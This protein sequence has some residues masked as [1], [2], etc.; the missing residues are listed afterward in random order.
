MGFIVSKLITLRAVG[1]STDDFER[2]F[3]AVR[4]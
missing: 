1:R 4:I 2:T 3:W